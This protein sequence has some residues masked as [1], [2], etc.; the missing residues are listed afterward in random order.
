MRWH[1]ISIAVE[2]VFFAIIIIFY[3]VPLLSTNIGQ[4]WVASRLAEN[5]GELRNARTLFEYAAR[6]HKTEEIYIGL[7]RIDL[8][9]EDITSASKT[10]L[11]SNDV[12][13]RTMI[14]VGDVYAHKQA[15]Q[16]ALAIY[17]LARQLY[18]AS[19]LVYYRLGKN[20]P[21]GLLSTVEAYQQ[22]IYLTNQGDKTLN[23][24]D[25][26]D[27]HI[28]L[29]QNYFW[30]G[31]YKEVI[32]QTNLA[33][34]L[35]QFSRAYRLQAIAYAHL[36]QFEQAESK[37]KEAIQIDSSFWPYLDWGDIYRVKGQIKLAAE[38]YE[39]SIQLAADPVAQVW[40]YTNLCQL[41]LDSKNALLA[42]QSCR[43]L[44]NKYANQVDFLLMLGNAY[45]LAGDRFSA[46]MQYRQ[47][48]KID[49]TNQPALQKLLKRN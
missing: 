42:V 21:P 8:I 4:L 41:Y 34:A 17:D 2:A 1:Q 16:R 28:Q 14:H 10:C 46:E 3:S 23:P 32:T 45:Q 33:L 48:L 22:A 15:S 20:Y 26:A 38:K 27:I 7:C 9:E 25:V 40:G 12:G 29:A 36:G 43:N 39:Q 47:V 11:L 44:V 5:K 13:L 24:G 19:A 6:W 31:A 18:P 30:W 35:G 49:P 37:I